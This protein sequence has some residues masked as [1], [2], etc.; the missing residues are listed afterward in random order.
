MVGKYPNSRDILSLEVDVVKIKKDF[1]TIDILLW[2]ILIKSNR[3]LFYLGPPKMH[4]ISY[5][6][7]KEYHNYTYRL[8]RRAAMSCS[9]ISIITVNLP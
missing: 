4:Y 7:L 9:N 3:V 6:R 5:C 8:C 1:M 2:E